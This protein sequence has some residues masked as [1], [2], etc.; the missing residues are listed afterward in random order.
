MQGGNRKPN[1]FLIY[2][3]WKKKSLKE[4]NDLYK[5]LLQRIERTP[6]SSK[7]ILDNDYEILRELVNYIEQRRQE[8][9]EK[10][11]DNR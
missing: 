3:S 10:N 4:L 5:M 9:E 1:N 11:N 2:E 8:E 7:S 6:S